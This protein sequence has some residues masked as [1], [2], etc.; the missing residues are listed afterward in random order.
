MKNY[1]IS[2]FGFNFD[3][4]SIYQHKITENKFQIVYKII[5]NIA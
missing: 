3:R 1:E 5:R 2:Y 4:I